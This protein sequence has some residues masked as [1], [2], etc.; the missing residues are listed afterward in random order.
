MEEGYASGNVLASYVHLH[1]GSAPD[2]AAALVARCREVDVAATHAAATSAAQSASLHRRG[3]SEAGLS[4]GSR[5]S[6]RRRHHQ[7][8]GMVHV[9]SVPNLAEVPHQAHLPRRGCV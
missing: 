2:F 1:F 3:S 7:T 6:G 8:N 9:R 4:H 5:G